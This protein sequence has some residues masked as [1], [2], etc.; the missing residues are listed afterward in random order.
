LAFR[1]GEGR[2][3]ALAAE[4][5]ALL[6]RDPPTP[7]LVA[8]NAQLANMEC[9]AGAYARAIAAADRACMLADE[10]GLPEPARAI[11]YR[12]FCRVYL[13]DRDGLA[14]MERG[15]ALLVESGASRDASAV[16]NNVALA[17]Y[18]IE[19]PGSSLAAFEDTIAFCLERGLVEGAIHAEA[20][21]PGLEAEL[22]RTTEALEHATRL[23]A[24][25]AARG[26]DATLIEVRSVELTTRLALG[27]REDSRPEAEL[28]VEMARAS[29]IV[30]RLAMGLAAAAAAVA[31]GA[32]E[33][34]AT[35]LTELVDAPGVHETTYYPRQLPGMVRT[36]LVI[37][38]PELASRLTDGL[39]V[40]YPLD[41]HARCAARASLAEYNDELAEAARLYAEAGLRW[42]GFGNVPESAHA[43]LGQGRCLVA[44]AADAGEPLR[45]AQGLFASL[46]YE[47]ARLE[48]EAL[49]GGL[50]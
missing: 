43:L 29:G 3:V 21:C 17:R 23:A 30:D 18:A 33:L 11:S 47:G 50:T 22:G 15:L 20:N 32:P 26:D 34:T 7:A 14:E 31:A 45:Q 38:H 13:G 5:V 19:G 44:L 35:L 8:A 40:R 1:L 49:L 6:E 46:G 10:L 36:A 28:L 48:T 16:Q 12:G 2:S 37:R 24:E 25:A 27:E 42:Q 9:L 41:E 4:A 39:K